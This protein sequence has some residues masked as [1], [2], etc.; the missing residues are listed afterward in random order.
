MAFVP[1]ARDHELRDDLRALVFRY[2]D[3]RDGILQLQAGLC[4][5]LVQLITSVPPSQL[6]L[7]LIIRVHEMALLLERL[8]KV[9]S[10]DVDDVIRRWRDEPP[11]A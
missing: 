3:S 9:P 5:I 11:P 7:D 6:R 10:E 2:A 4:G 1:S 8:E